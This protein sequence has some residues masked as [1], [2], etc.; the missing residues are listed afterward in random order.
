MP[1]ETPVQKN[2]I[3]ASAPSR[4]PRGFKIALLVL[5]GL[6]IFAAVGLYL[7]PGFLPVDT[8]RGI[9]KAK[10]RELAGMDVDFKNLR[11]G[12]NGDVVLDDVTLAR[13][14]ADGNPETPLL[15]IREART[16]VALAPLM[17]G[18]AIVNSISVDGFILRIHRDANG[19][20]NLPD[21]AA[22]Q[23]RLQSSRRNNPPDA[24]LNQSRR[25]DRPSRFLLAAQQPAA[26]DPAATAAAAADPGIPPIEL[27]HLELRNGI[28][29]LEDDM[30]GLKL[31]L[32][33]DFL[34]LEGK[35]LND[36]FDVAGRLIPY[37]EAPQLGGL[38]FN[39][40]VA[41]VKDNAFDPNGVANLEV[42]VDKFSLHEM[43]LKLGLGELVQSGMAHGNLK[44]AYAQGKGFVDITE[45]HLGNVNL[46][47]K[48]GL[49]LEL[50]DTTFDLKTTVDPEAGR[51]DLAHASFINSI[52]SLTAQGFVGD[53][54]NLATGGG[55]SSELDFTGFTDFAQAGQYL[56]SAKLDLPDLPQL[57]GTGNFKGK[58][59]LPPQTVA[60]PLAPTLALDFTDGD[61]Q[62]L[63]K[64][65][66][67]VAKLKLAGIGLRSNAV[68]TNPPQ[69]N[70]NLSF[71]AIPGSLF[72]PDLAHQALN[73]VANGG[74]AL[75][76]TPDNQA[77]ELR[78]KDSRAELPATPWTSP[79]SL[80]NH[81]T[82]I[83][84]D[85]LQDVISIQR[86]N[87]TANDV[88][89]GGVVKAHLTGLMAGN[90]QGEA[91]LELTALLEHLR[92][93]FA[94]IFPDDLAPRLEGALRNSTR[95][96]IQDGAAEALVRTE[97]DDA[98]LAF[99][100]KPDTAS[101][102]F[103]AP[104]ATF[105]VMANL[106]L[107]QPS[108]LTIQSLEASGNSAIIHY[109]D[110]TSGDTASGSVGAGIFRLA[111]VI[112]AEQGVG[113][114]TGLSFDAGGL[115]LAL[116]Q[117]GEKRASVGSGV[118]KAVLATPDK[119]LRF[120]LG[121]QGDFAL[122]NMDFG[123]D[124]L[125]FQ[126]GSDQSHF[127]NV[128]A[129]LAVDG[130]VG[131]DKRQ[132]IN[133]RT[134]TLS[135]H[136]VAVNSRGQ[137]DLGSG[138]ILAEYAAR[139]A[140]TGMASL[141]AYLGLPPALLN[142][143]ALSGSV[144][145][146]GSQI[147]AKGSTQGRLAV[148]PGQSNPF[149]IAHDLTAALNAA[150]HSLALDIRRLDGSI[151]TAAGEAVTT[152]QAQQSKL[153]LSRTGAK[154]FMDVR[155]KGSAAHT[156]ALALGFT[157][158]FPRLQEY[159]NQLNQVKADGIY[160]AWIQIKEK[161][162][163][164]VTVNTGGEWQGAALAVDGVPYLAEAAKLSAALVGDISFQDRQVRLSRLMLHSDSGQM[165]AEG[166]A[167]LMYT[168]DEQQNPT[169]LAGLEAA[170]RFK[171]ADLARTAMVFPGVIPAELGLSGTVEGMV[172][173]GGNANDIQVRQS[174]VKFT[175]FR[176]KPKPQLELAIPN[177]SATLGAHISLHTADARG[178]SPLA[179][180]HMF[181][182]KNGQA[183]LQ[184]A[185]ILGKN[186]D[187][188]SSQ[189]QL[190]KGVLTLHDA[191]LQMGGGSEGVQAKG[192]VD[193]NGDHPLGL[194][195]LN[196]EARFA[197]ADAADLM[198][199][200]PD[201]LP[202]GAAVTGRID[203]ALRLAGT[204]DNI[205]IGEC[206]LRFQRFQARPNPDFEID[207]PNGAASLAG[208]VSLHMAGAR[209]GSPFDALRLFDVHNG[210]MAL[211]GARMLG[212]NIDEMS[213][214]FQ[215]EQGVLTLH[216]AR[217]NVGGGAESFSANGSVN[218]N[219]NAPLGIAHL[220]VDGKFAIAD[221]QDAVRMFPGLL[222]PEMAVAGGV[223]G[224]MRAGGA[225]D[226]IRIGEA[227]VRFS[228]FRVRPS[229]A[230]E[231]AIPSG[232][233]TFSADV[234]LHFSGRPSAAPHAILRMFDIRNGQADVKGALVRNKPVNEMSTAFQLEQGVLTLHHARLQVGHNG[235]EGD[236]VTNGV[237]DFNGEVP[238]VNSRVA[239]RNLPMA[240]F[241]DEI[242][243]F[244]EITQGVLHIPAAAQ[245]GA[246]G[247]AFAGFAEDEI[248]RTLRL[249]NFTFSTGPLELIT[250]PALNAELDRARNLMRQEIHGDKA[251]RI[252]F[253]SVTGSAH[254]DGTGVIVIPA[255]KPIRLDGDNTGDF[256]AHG[257]VTAEHTMDVKVMVV[258]KL[259]RLIGFTVPNL[260]PHIRTNQEEHSRFM[261][262]MNQNAAKGHY[263][264]TVRGNL[265]NPDIS[266]IG[267][268][269][270]VFLKDIVTSIPAELFGGL[271]GAGKDAPQNL[272]ELGQNVVGGIVSG[273]V[274]PRDALK[275][276]Q[277]G[278]RQSPEQ[279]VKN[280]GQ[281]FGFGR[282]QEQQAA[283]QPPQQ[284]Y[285]NQQPFAP[286]EQQPQP[287]QQQQRGRGT[288]RLPF[289]FQ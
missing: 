287:Q 104:K 127:G 207:V 79:L 134:A 209:T 125:V 257:V 169:G 190:D 165:Q 135:A 205:D 103:N 215:L 5:L 161:D 147:S 6:F 193:F 266:G 268:L 8:I 21:P 164:A 76:H 188:M 198:R 81:E 74:A 258:G 182:I 222:P 18:K 151:K 279:A 36:P 155:V 115:S 24:D 172:Q 1:S 187:A 11:F 160:N 91:D 219:S 123:V 86:L 84:A 166:Q 85:L 37:P 176:A 149:E 121:P 14:D 39:G 12:W 35:T 119:P 210:K 15:H 230:L 46:G 259:E 118:L 261:D 92:V 157:G 254:A 106:N 120:P 117:H 78:L 217:L 249:D 112:D 128:R 247:V 283:P 271:L 200:L 51:A 72:V 216:D 59:I 62:V 40:R 234:G 98:N 156:R 184:G 94:P 288:F 227:A 211:Q 83:T 178:A 177:G 49:A 179:V 80:V 96:K 73:F 146:N 251:R 277:E 214:S 20:L 69:I 185:T 221:L 133:L 32:G 70:A 212:K 66:G 191:R 93:I 213:S 282:G 28:I 136:P 105:A 58:L 126:Y 88:I 152:L 19:E 192:V 180:M 9:A 203:G 168:A 45:M 276:V 90:P 110:Q 245:G 229:P 195:R 22:V 31:D 26:A 97:L 269:A 47:L 141:L 278:F 3:D 27:H 264:V 171:A 131:P 64:H 13:L 250:G 101:A 154:G 228:N 109:Q 87:V 129:R 30:A 10:A 226:D 173:A 54:H 253:T 196:L 223:E 52:A 170:F 186:I 44:A 53:F 224:M 43:A 111:G 272:R 114:L 239:I 243:Q 285:H 199:Y 144:A 242:K 122:G 140:P 99:A 225:V 113:E 158:I 57:D 218:F 55:I 240:E 89:R 233:A 48:P 67:N 41:M 163:G 102:E 238:T 194:G 202:A 263:G 237:V 65:S 244:F 236:V 25:V 175:N 231:V 167:N 100:V 252:S 108:R 71:A 16:N 2:K 56:A 138:A 220:F 42:L 208:K 260:V 197:L 61:L 273:D 142:E 145:W 130:Y 256:A 107:D 174:N 274:N 270:G 4:K 68:V 29:G 189:F 181:D 124:N 77:L 183:S 38:P 139:V 33:L 82:R 7:L 60:G 204:P 248:L 275:S 232:I 75:V 17:S 255:E 206:A 116:G 95:L 241:N 23:Q 289:G 235:A 132:L 284:P 143:A 265:E 281:M 262:R 63:E 153:L 280:L 286:Q 159:A 246:A 267:Q 50:P 137:F 162:A 34:R 150:D 201:A 148:A